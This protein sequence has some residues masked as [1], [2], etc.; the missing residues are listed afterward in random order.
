MSAHP[1]SGEAERVLAGLSEAERL[2]IPHMSDGEFVYPI[3]YTAADA[4]VPVKEAR[5]AFRQLRAA[6]LAQHG[7][8]YNEDEWQPCGSGTWLTPLGLAVRALLQEL[9]Q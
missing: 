5:V 6:G 4:G 1:A 8:L 7:V 2:L 9:N 3:A